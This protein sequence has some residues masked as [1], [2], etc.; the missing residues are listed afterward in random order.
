MASAPAQIPTSFGHELRACLRCR[1]V[2]TY[3][4]VLLPFF[5]FLHS[6][7]KIMRVRSVLNIKQ[8]LFLFHSLESQAVR[9]ALFLR[10]KKIMSVL[11]IALPPIL[12]GMSVSILHQNPIHL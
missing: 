6:L 10:W 9:T 1:L 7:S 2:K 12:M 8:L 4:Q 3:D 11:L 5:I